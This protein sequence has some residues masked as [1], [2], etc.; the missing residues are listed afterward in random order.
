MFKSI[1]L[2]SPIPLVYNIKP[3]G[4][5]FL[6]VYNMNNRSMSSIIK[7]SQYEIRHGQPWSYLVQ[8]RIVTT[9]VSM[10]KWIPLGSPIPLVYNLLGNGFPLGSPI[11]LVYNIKPLGLLLVLVY[12]INNRS[13]SS[14]IKCHILTNIVSIWK[15][16]M[17]NHGH[18]WSNVALWQQLSQCLNQFPWVHQFLWFIILNPYVLLISTIFNISLSLIDPLGF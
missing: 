10:L 5:L 7:L 2:G 8:H 18:S 1:P 11:P 14:M 6:L 4:L 13:M 3:L 17:A 16:P 12:N 15:S 9:I